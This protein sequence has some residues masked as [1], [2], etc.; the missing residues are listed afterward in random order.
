M[1]SAFER[2]YPK[3]KLTLS[4][5]F[6]CLLRILIWWLNL[7]KL[8]EGQ[9]WWKSDKNQVTQVKMS[10]F[11][12]VWLQPNMLKFQPGVCRISTRNFGHLPFLNVKRRSPKT[13]INTFRPKTEDDRRFSVETSLSKF[14]VKVVWMQLF[15]KVSVR[16]F[17]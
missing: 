3:G 17:L 10:Q 15:K 4:N 7:N 1:R 2:T 11:S 12:V 5:F 14:L 13:L 8:E 9:S 6:V 16:N